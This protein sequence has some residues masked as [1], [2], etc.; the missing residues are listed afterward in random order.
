ML[1]KHIQRDFNLHWRPIFEIMDACP[2]LHL[3]DDPANN[4]NDSF[5]HAMEFLK[6]RVQYVFQKIKANPI[7]WELLTWSK[8]VRHSSA[9]KY[10]TESDKA[11]LPPETT[12]FYKACS[13][14]GLLKKKE[15]VG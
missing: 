9:M 5:D 1:P 3:L 4:L 6:T 15:T 10:G 11:V 13:T 12:R 2:G 14:A 8:H 7:K